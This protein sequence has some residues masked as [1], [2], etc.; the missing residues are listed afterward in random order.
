MDVDNHLTLL[1]KLG[2]AIDAT[3]Q[4]WNAYIA[5]VS[6]WPTYENI[7]T[8]DIKDK[9]TKSQA[10][11]HLLETLP[12]RHT[13]L[14]HSYNDPEL[15]FVELSEVCARL[16]EE[17]QSPD[18]EVDLDKDFNKL[19]GTSFIKTVVS[20]ERKIADE[21]QWRSQELNRLKASHTCL[22]TVRED[23]ELEKGEVRALVDAMEA[24]G[25]PLIG[26][27]PV[28]L[29]GDGGSQG[30]GVSSPELHPHVQG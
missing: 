2:S 6:Q 3:L 26:L 10:L 17:L 21:E 28:E 14:V 5:A 9:A 30:I 25:I 16:V 27:G 22:M 15:G 11:K 20:L 23:G 8:G 18:S 24:V 29:I 12:T 19:A 13:A 1:P 7:I 4:S